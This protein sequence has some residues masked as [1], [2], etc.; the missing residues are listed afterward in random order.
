MPITGDPP[1]PSGARNV[2]ELSARLRA[3]QAWAGV[4]YREV[5]R[6]VV[7]DRR[8]R[9]VV[10]VPSY[11]TVYRCLQPGRSRLD[12]ELVADIARV[13]LGDD[14]LVV[15]WRQAYQVVTGR[16]IDA[17]LV[18]VS[19]ALP[20]VPADFTGRETE[21]ELLQEAVD[22]G[23]TVIAIDGMAGVGKTALARVLAHRI[24]DR[25]EVQLGVNLR[26][27]DPDRPPADPGAVLDGFLRRLGVAGAQIHGLDLSARIARF[28]RL[29]TGRKTLLVL[30]N[31]AS[32]EQVRP[33]LPGT[34]D[35]VTVVTARHRL[36]LP[37]AVAVQL[38]VLPQDEAVAML[39]RV[40]GGIVSEPD[41]HRIAELTG[42][43]PLALSLAGGRIRA[44]PGWSPADHVERL[45]ERRRNL[46]L[47]SGVELALVSSYD[48]Q[49]DELR[50]MLRL[51]GLMPGRAFDSYAAA[52]LSGTTAAVARDA[53]DGLTAASLVER[54]MPD[55]YE[56]HD[57]VRVFAAARAQD[58]EAPAAR[59]RALTRLFDHYRAAAGAAID[60]YV[61]H[62][63]YRRPDL[64]TPASELPGFA[65]S[66]TAHAWLDLER[67]N[68]L[69]VAAYCGHNG[70]PEHTAH[71]SIILFRYLDVAGRYQDSLALHGLARQVADPPLAGRAL[72]YLSI[73]RIT[74]GEYD[75]ARR[76]LAEAREIFAAA[77]DRVS[78]GASL[79][80]IAGVHWR[81]GRYEDAIEAFDQALVLMRETG[82]PSMA[83]HALSSIG[84]VNYLLGR[85][86]EALEVSAE[87]L[88][89]ARGMGDTVAVA[90][91]LTMIG[92]VYERLGDYDRAETAIGEALD[93]VRQVGYR[94]G[95]ADAL[96]HLGAIRLAQGRLDE[97][98]AQFPPALET[99]R[100][101]GVREI[102]LQVLN[103]YG[104]ALHAAGRTGSAVRC[105]KQALR[106]ATAIDDRYEL[107][108]AHDGLGTALAAAGRSPAATEHLRRALALFTDLGT[109][110]AA[111]V[112]AALA[113]FS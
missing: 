19:D 113:R 69:A 39:R 68:L 1:G 13:L 105:L 40:A 59:R 101:D 70:W 37:G 75:E 74:L 51:L 87:A 22:D 65:D 10:E 48:A 71:L 80:S 26:G 17:S 82:D 111:A 107:A 62:E 24:A 72:Y 49:P 112:S 28:R 78:E 106:L 7:R 99:A 16:A 57:L 79:T 46:R 18:T 103:R 15:E 73:A 91:T 86:D 76:G 84:M 92:G 31:A 30:D 11:N 58:E 85:Y 56:L 8:H 9:G 88:E 23:A 64:G 96:S 32:P 102:E 108:R 34:P 60:V 97:A 5:H 2:D 89:V 35:C 47:D 100:A 4:P 6:R 94:L 44:T 83:G 20:V 41:A 81:T 61:P 53:L 109:P 77:G 93:S 21:L 33:L 63:R 55:R 42:R 104:Q 29:L 67:A 54:R 98:L 90:H 50:R 27:Y 36:D 110:E 3:L 43:L 45:G 38:G 25:T 14:E 95:E 12:R 52:A 66:D